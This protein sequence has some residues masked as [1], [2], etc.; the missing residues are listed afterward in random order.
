MRSCAPRCRFERKNERCC[1]Y[2]R[3]TRVEPL[4]NWILDLRN[5]PTFWPPPTDLPSNSKQFVLKVGTNPTV[6]RQ[7]PPTS[8][9]PS[10]SQFVATRLGTSLPFWRAFGT[11][12]VGSWYVLSEQEVSVSAEREGFEPSIR[13]RVYYLSKVARSTALPPLRMSSTSPSLAKF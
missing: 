5:K 6:R 12:H 4:R 9:L 3:N 7:I 11:A 10:L 8:S 2:G 1:N 13:F